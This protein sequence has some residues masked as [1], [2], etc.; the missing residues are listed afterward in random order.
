ME[1]IQSIL[2][3]ATTKTNKIKMLLRLGMTRKQVAEAMGVGYGFVQ[4][5]YASVYGVAHPRKFLAERF[6]FNRTFGVEM[7]IIHNSKSEVCGALR[8]SGVE[9]VSESY[10]HTTRT[11]WKIV[12]DASVEG[13]FEI[14][15]PVLKGRE[16]LD[17]LK[18]VCDALVGAG[19][20]IKK[21]CGL[22]VHLGTDDFK[23]D[24]RVWKNLYKNYATL[25]SI[26]D[27]F[28]PPSRRDNR[29]CQ[30]MRVGG[31]RG[32]IG[33]ARTLQDLESKITGRS[34][35][36]KL[37]SQSY[38][39]HRTVEFRQHS[40]SVEFEKVKNWI[41]FCARFVEFSK[42]NAVQ[43]GE[44]AEL[45]KFLDSDLINF[46]DNRAAKFAA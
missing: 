12:S 18:K 14:V 1:N 16:G 32:K 37:N 17:E 22:H 44:K 20:K 2:E 39:R 10:N 31:W 26:I 34:R 41:L 19:A 3:Q 9:C 28:M 27:S 38:W 11:H 25:E 36:F 23:A 5:V 46:Y 45:K 4:N 6:F 8:R 33:S 35:Y 13:G 21:C 24:I 42:K 29:F 15:S 40:G 7:E 43:S 30:S